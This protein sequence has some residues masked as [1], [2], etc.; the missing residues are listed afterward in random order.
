[1]MPAPYTAPATQ[2]PTALLSVRAGLF[3]W[4]DQM[5]EIRTGEDAILGRVGNGASNVTIGK[6]IRINMPDGE[7]LL[8]RFTEL[9]VRLAALDRAQGNNSWAL[10]IIALALV[11]QTIWVIQ[12]QNSALQDISNKISDT[13]RHIVRLE[14][15]WVTSGRWRDGTPTPPIVP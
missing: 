8:T 11:A 6:D 3:L 15:L 10:L 12:S 14:T 2:T 7:P 13:N 1:M 5:A 4:G 9:E